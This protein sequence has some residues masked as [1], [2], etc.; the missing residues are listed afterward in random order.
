M[1]KKARQAL[2]ALARD[3]AARAEAQAALLGSPLA[4]QKAT[5]AGV[6]ATRVATLLKSGNSVTAVLVAFQAIDIA[7]E[8]EAWRITE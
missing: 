7:V 5:E 4:Q 2:V 8:L 6:L 3:A 1:K